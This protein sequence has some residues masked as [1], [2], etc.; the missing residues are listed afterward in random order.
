L[1]EALDEVDGDIDR[2]LEIGKL[3]AQPSGTRFN[4]AKAIGKG[5]LEFMR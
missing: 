2:D 3:P 4:H 5:C 1:G